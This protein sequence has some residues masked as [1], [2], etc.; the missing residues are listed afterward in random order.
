MAAAAGGGSPLKKTKGYLA[1]ILVNTQKIPAIPFRQR[2]LKSASSHHETINWF[3]YSPDFLGFISNCKAN[4][5]QSGI[6]Y[7]LAS[8]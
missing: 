7:R 1:C 6:C 2:L 5:M 4:W 8:P 3:D